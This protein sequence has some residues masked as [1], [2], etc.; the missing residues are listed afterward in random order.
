MVCWDAM[1]EFCTMIRF[2]SL[3][4][5]C[6]LFLLCVS[7]ISFDLVGRAQLSYEPQERVLSSKDSL[8]F[9]TQMWHA[10]PEAEVGGIALAGGA[11][12]ASEIPGSM[13]R[14]SS[15]TLRKMSYSDPIRTLHALAGVNVVAEDGFGLRPN[16]G[17]R[18]SGT[19]RSSRIT[20]MEDGV[21]M[22]PAPYAAPSAYYFPTIARMEGVE[23]RKGGSQIA[24][25]P[26]TAGGALNLVSSAIPDAEVAGRVRFESGSF[27]NQ[28]MHALVGG[29]QGQWGYSLE[30]MQLSSDGFKVLDTGE[31]TG[32][33]KTDVVAKLQWTST[34]GK[35]KVRWKGAQSGES[36]RETYL[37]LAAQD[38]ASNPFRRYA[39]SAKDLML[40]DHA[41]VIVGHEFKPTSR[42]SM[43]TEAYQ[44]WFARN[45]Y[46]LDRA[47]DSTGTKLALG[48]ILTDPA[49]SQALGWLQG[50]S[51]EPGAGLDVKAN[52]RQY[53]AR[54]V[55]HRGRWSF[56]G[57]QQHRLTYGVR[58]HE[59]FMDRYQ[60]RDRYA[61]VD[62]QMALVAAGDSGSAGNRIESARALAGHVRA[63]FHVGAWTFT[64]GVRH[65]RMTLARQDFGDDLAR[66]GEGT[67]RSND[68]SV[69]L[70]GLGAHVDLVPNLWTAFAGVHRGF[71]P[72]GSAPDTEPEFS[73]HLEVGTRLSSRMVSGQITLFH[74]EHQN[75]LGADLTA[76]GGTGSGDLFN[77]GSSRAQG[78]E[79]EAVGDVLELT[80]AS[81][82]FADDIHHFPVRVSYTYTQ[83]VF[84]QAFESE[85]DPWGVVEEGDALP[86][87]APH[88]FSVAASWE[89]PRWSYDLNLR[90]MS[91][92]RTSASQGELNPSQSTDA[93]A[94]LDAGIRFQAQ[95]HLEWFAGVTNV[96]NDTYV[97]A[98][99]PYGLRPGM[100]RAFRAGATLSF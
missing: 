74:S 3:R 18:G 47:V 54:G 12:D 39:A 6:G 82:F 4:G 60:W 31:D 13:Q 95:A 96:L 57:S 35:H 72:P 56:G 41:H 98:R 64:P 38:F 67:Q 23:V 71:V 79:V 55:Q 21:L 81:A 53:G 7:W 26:Q 97:V 86:Y 65:E 88:Q 99:R 58:A 42:W 59:D 43:T 89:A 8:D 91:A 51:T 25:G 27:R 50:V 14:L 83:A 70:P 24:F 76:S 28:Q 87:L 77:G 84:T 33:D 49:M 16:V 68:I 40:T 85:F 69:W 92:M 48:D 29:T 37:G 46:K 73:N 63:A 44:T 11:S 75:L 15:K 32:F 80:G 1:V 94:V 22:A 5:F 61:M 17:M 20:L 78:I 100:P 30:F 2:T 52:N 62:G 90:G 93:M 45:W 66:L 36:S 19:E 34:S 9:M 10:L